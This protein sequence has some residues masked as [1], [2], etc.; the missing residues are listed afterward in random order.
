MSQKGIYKKANGPG[1]D[2]DPD[3]KRAKENKFFEQA[4]SDEVAT[5][6]KS[7]KK[8]RPRSDHKHDY[9]SV[10]VWRKGYYTERLYG[11]VA[12]RCAICGKV[13]TFYH[14]RAY[15]QEQKYLGELKH[16]FEVKDTI[17]PIPNT[18]YQ[19]IVYLNGS[20]NVNV[21]TV[22][23]KNKMIDMMHRNYRFIIGDFEGA[24]IQMQKLLHECGYQN[25]VVYYKGDYPL[26]NLGDWKGK[27]LPYN[28][29]EQALLD[30]NEG[31]MVIGKE[32]EW[33]R[34]ALQKLIA[35][36][37]Q[38]EVCIF[39]KGMAEPIFAAIWRI[40]NEKDLEWLVERYKQWV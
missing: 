25:V 19:K 17:M 33:W 12:Q 16:F 30:C 34:V 23:V 9:E 14:F 4:A 26:V 6:K 22:D 21:L 7:E 2:Y 32:E 8:G 15:R 39:Q 24:S 29:Q 38:C 13:E 36:Q 37:K 10:Y 18:E 5:R 11:A 3:N 1:W 35:N 28:C 20:K 40:G 31:F 27:H